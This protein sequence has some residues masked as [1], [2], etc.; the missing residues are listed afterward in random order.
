[1]VATVAEE[2]RED[3]LALSCMLVGPLIVS[4]SFGV[5][6]FG[7]PGSVPWASVLSDSLK[8]LPEMLAHIGLSARLASWGEESPVTLMV[9]RW[10]PLVMPRTKDGK[11]ALEVAQQIAELEVRE[12]FP[13]EGD[14]FDPLIEAPT[15]EDAPEDVSKN[16]ARRSEESGAHDHQVQQHDSSTTGDRP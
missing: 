14:G 13:S 5:E 4:R 6:E 1:M 2:L 16:E 8:T 11:H 15:S 12:Y 3:T 7:K 9:S 10:M